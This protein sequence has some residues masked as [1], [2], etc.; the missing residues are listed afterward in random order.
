MQTPPLALAMILCDEVWTDPNTG[1]K[2]ILGTFS[3]IFGSAF[4]LRLNQLS[5][6]L[7]LTDAH[8][9]VSMKMRIIDVDEE[10]SPV[11]EKDFNPDFP[12]PL[13]VLEATLKMTGLV[14]P[15]DGEYRV[16]LFCADELLIERRV[17]VTGPGSTEDDDVER[18]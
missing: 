13:A 10:Q 16:Q 2:S 1:K 4:P 14:F 6:Y 5:V 3:A 17:I 7:A 15:V 18:D 9:P 12:D 8:G 11:F